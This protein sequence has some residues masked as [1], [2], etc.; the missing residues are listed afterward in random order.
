[1]HSSPKVFNHARKNPKNIFLEQV[2]K[3][4]NYD[5]LNFMVEGFTKSDY[6]RNVRL[7]NIVNEMPIWIF[8][9]HCLQLGTFKIHKKSQK[10]L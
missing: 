7:Q 10:T 5:F 2:I 1:M 4:Y 3:R 9:N 6:T 8:R